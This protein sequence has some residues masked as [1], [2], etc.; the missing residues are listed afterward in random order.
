M[1]TPEW[2]APGIYGALIGAAFVG[3]VGFTWGG[4]VTG[5]T[6]HDRAMSMSHDDV[7]ASMVPVC[8]DMARS[9]PARAEKL[10]TI[11]AVSA[12]KRRDALM[13]AGWATMP[14]S[15]APDRDIARA[16]LQE[17]DL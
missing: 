13:E 8:L 11:R 15:D 4:W 14:G 12:Y 6:A 9:D 3:I 5:S 7:V 17:L 16:C 2:L 1:N 10:E